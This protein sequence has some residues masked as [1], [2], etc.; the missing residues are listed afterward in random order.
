VSPDKVVLESLPM[1]HHIPT[2]VL[3]TVGVSLHATLRMSVR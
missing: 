1:G 3:G 2:A